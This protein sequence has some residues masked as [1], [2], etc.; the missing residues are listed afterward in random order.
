MAQLRLLKVG[1]ELLS[2]RAKVFVTPPSDALRV[3]VCVELTVETV[4]VKDA[5][6]A[7]DATVTLDGTV[8][9]VLL[10]DND[11]ASPLPEAALPS[12][13]VHESVPAAV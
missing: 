13:T 3:A 9:A 11:T 8:T 2:C 12:V 4:A 7:P 6:V 1:V 10:L 5:L